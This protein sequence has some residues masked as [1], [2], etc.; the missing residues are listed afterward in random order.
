MSDHLAERG[1]ERAWQAADDVALQAAHQRDAIAARLEA[2]L[3]HLGGRMDKVERSIEGM[4]TD[5]NR[6]LID[7]QPAV[8]RSIQRLDSDNRHQDKLIND[9]ALQIKSL[10]D[11]MLAFRVESRRDTSKLLA[12]IWATFMGVM[13]AIAA[14]VAAVLGIF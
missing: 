12:S 10:S 1:R 6:H 7:Q 2:D 9:N 14:Q 3:G 11:Q 8:D 13:I 4:R 5:L